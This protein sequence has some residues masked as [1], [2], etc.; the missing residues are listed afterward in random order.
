[1]IK[2]IPVWGYV[3]L[4][5]W[6]VLPAGAQISF[7]GNN[8]LEYSINRK[9]DENFFENWTDLF[10]QWKNW[11]T[12]V[13]YEFHLPPQ[14]FSQDTVGQGIAQRF[15]EYRQKEFS[16]TLGNFYT[17]LGK[18]LVLRSFENRQIRWD[19]NIDGAKI[20]FN[21]R[22]LDLNLLGGRPRDRSGRRHEVLQA[23]QINLKPLDWF[24]VGATMLYTRLKSKGK[25][26]WGSVFGGLNLNFGNLYAEYA[27]KKYPAAYPQGSAFYGMGNFWL[28]P[29]TLLL[30][31]RDYDQFDLTEGLTYNNPPT[32]VREHLYTLLN[33]HQH[34]MEANDEKGYLLELGYAFSDWGVLTLNHSRT[35]N[36]AG[37]MLY[38]EYYGQVELD[39]TDDWSLV[40]ATGEQRDLE[41]RYLNF[42]GTAK[43]GFT[44]YDA[45][46]MIYE[47]QHVKIL[48]NDRQFYNQAVS[49]N[50]EHSPVFTLSLLAERT[51]DQFSERKI[52]L[53]GQAAIHFLEQYDLTIFAGSRR[54]G[55]I[56]AGGVCIYQP[57]FE[58]IEFRLINQ[59]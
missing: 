59:F 44:G 55:K 16:F 7:Q 1:M 27:R 54:E 35:E 41:A 28:G 20:E 51:T 5:V 40:G 8:Y 30:E 31:Y 19:T 2:K 49:L 3:F 21:N 23:G 15:L 50:W 12:G 45:L 24:N 37:L 57:E 10:M 14:P 6:M 34:V 9:L 38:R 58:G 22:Y 43:W 29:V 25:V 42:V 47:H 46:K 53:G 56:C 39:P 4:L 32:A 11:R 13:R 52:W 33:R 48:L 26:Q 18:G 17:L 36:H